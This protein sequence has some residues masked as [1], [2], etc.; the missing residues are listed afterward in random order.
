VIVKDDNVIVITIALMK[1]YMI[2]TILLAVVIVLII[3]IIILWKIFTLLES[4]L[5]RLERI[6]SVNNDGAIL[7]ALASIKSEIERANSRWSFFPEETKKNIYNIID[8]IKKS[9]TK[10]DSSNRE[11]IN[12]LE[13][14]YASIWELNNKLDISNAI[15]RGH[16]GQYNF[17]LGEIADNLEKINNEI[18]KSKFIKLLYYFQAGF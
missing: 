9:N 18:K 11:I 16:S 10:N 13:H 4:S 15:G 17:S 2:Y 6:L 7:G 8:T 5:W 12:S 3:L 14:L 1:D